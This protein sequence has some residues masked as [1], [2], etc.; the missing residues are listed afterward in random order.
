MDSSMP[1]PSGLVGVTTTFLPAPTIPYDPA[2][3][4]D[5]FGLTVTTYTSRMAALYPVARGQSNRSPGDRRYLLAMFTDIY[6]ETDRLVVRPFT[7]GDRDPL[8]FLPS[9]VEIFYGVTRRL[10]NRGIA[11]EA[12]AA[13]LE[14][15]FSR[16]G[17][18]RIVGAVHPEHTASKRVLEKMGMSYDRVVTGLP[19]EHRAYEGTF[20]YSLTADEWS[21][22]DHPGLSPGGT[23]RRTRGNR[24]VETSR[25]VSSHRRLAHRQPL[26]RPMEPVP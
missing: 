7:L 13:M 23:N 26:P 4:K 20:A 5:N 18:R 12:A 16:I 14:Y 10:W 2:R 22:R 6:I 9:E 3:V 21:H 17:L 8:A 25:G 11:T 15:G 24:D 1:T 19:A